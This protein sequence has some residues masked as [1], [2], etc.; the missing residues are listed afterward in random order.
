M[1]IDGEPAFEEWKKKSKRAK[2]VV[3]IK[4]RF[5]LTVS[6]TNVTPEIARDW[7]GLVGIKRIAKLGSG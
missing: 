7:V 3:L 4:D 6:G 5:L 1:K 2:V